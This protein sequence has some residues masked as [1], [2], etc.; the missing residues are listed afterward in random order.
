MFQASILL[1]AYAGKLCYRFLDPALYIAQ[2]AGD[3]G[4]RLVKGYATVGPLF[5]PAPL[6]AGHLFRLVHAN[7]AGSPQPARIQ[8]QIVLYGGKVQTLLNQLVDGGRIVA[9]LGNDVS[10]RLVLLEKQGKTVSETVLCY[11]RFVKL[12]SDDPTG[13]HARGD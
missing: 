2:L 4:V 13:H 3:A 12:I 5:L 9:P 11:C 7:G 1:F 8:A 6:G 10:Q